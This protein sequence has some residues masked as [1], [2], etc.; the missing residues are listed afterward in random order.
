[1]NKRWDH[2]I[3]GTGSA[4]AVVAARLSEDPT[5]QVLALE[6]GP[7]YPTVEET[8]QDIRNEIGRAHV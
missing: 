7:D 1:M 6:A 8:P 2:I 5:L 3:V 4:G